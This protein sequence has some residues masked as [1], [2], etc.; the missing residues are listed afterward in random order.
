MSKRKEERELKDI[1]RDLERVERLEEEILENETKRAVSARLVLLDS[2]GN[3]MPLSV[4][5]NDVPG[6]ALL[7]EFSGANGTGIVVPPTGAVTYASDTPTVATVDP[8]TGALAYV[9]PGSANISGTDA[10]SGLTA[11]DVLTVSNAAA[12]SA[13]MT[14]TA[15]V[16]PAAAAAAALKR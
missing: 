14:L 4:H 11:S 10:G 2:K 3:K 13:T 9:G 6:S 15:G 7:Q 5:I 8:N 16:S 1:R 12:V